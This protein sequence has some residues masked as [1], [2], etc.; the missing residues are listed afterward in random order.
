MEKEYLLLRDL[1]CRYVRQALDDYSPTRRQSF[2][3]CRLVGVLFKTMLKID[4]GGV[5]DD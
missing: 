1:L 3:F 4:I 5:S 2:E